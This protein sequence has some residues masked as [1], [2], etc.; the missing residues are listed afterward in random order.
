MI[1]K[2]TKPYIIEG[3]IFEEGEELVISSDGENE[4]LVEPKTEPEKEIDFDLVKNQDTVT[5]KQELLPLE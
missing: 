4:V 3:K 1:I 5:T 2:L